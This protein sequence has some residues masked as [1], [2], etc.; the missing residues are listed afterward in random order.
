MKLRIKIILCLV[1]LAGL[2]ILGCARR[3]DETV[4]LKHYPITSANEVLTKTNIALD[5]DVTND[6]NGSLTITAEKPSTY[7]LFETGDIDIENARLIY[8]ATL[9]TKDVE[10]E[11][12]LEMW[13]HFPGKGEYFSRALHDPLTGTIDWVHQETPFFL[14]A[15]E[16]PDNVKLNLV[17]DGT[18]TVWIDD[19]KLVRGSL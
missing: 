9:K 11:V 8:E 16:N 15:G 18:G 2:L 17:V 6:G 4:E 5:T 12:Y 1:V 7:R 10:G 13:C 3:A 19:I 14:K